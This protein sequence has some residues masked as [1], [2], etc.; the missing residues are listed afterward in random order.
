MNAK[1]DCLEAPLHLAA[2]AG[3]L[4]TVE[5]LLQAGAAIDLKDVHGG[6]P[7]DRARATGRGEIV[8]VLLKAGA[9]FNM[10]GADKNSKLLQR[11]GEVEAVP[12]LTSGIEYGAGKIQ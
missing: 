3:G 8:K 2:E 7:M 12:L 10:D 6:T 9:E 1:D 5:L 11:E 4:E